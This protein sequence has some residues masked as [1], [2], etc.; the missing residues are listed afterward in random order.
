[1][2]SKLFQDSYV[3]IVM[4]LLA[5]KSFSEEDALVHL[6]NAETDIRIH[7]TGV[8]NPTWLRRRNIYSVSV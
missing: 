4:R 1:M 3:L 2:C 5:M 8:Q 6:G 7:S